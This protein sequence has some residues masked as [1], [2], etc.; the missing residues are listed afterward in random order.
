MTARELT[1]LRAPW[2]QVTGEARQKSGRGSVLG[3][4][5]AR[6]TRWWELPLECGH[7]E[8]RIVRYRPH[9]DGWPAQVGG[10]QHRGKDD[11]LPAPKRVRCDRCRLRL[12]P[13]PF[14]GPS[15]PAPGPGVPAG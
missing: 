11:V 15:R 3:P 1:E 13:G 7:T 9:Q 6:R 5:T 10:T 2:R 12:A 8:E 4:D 14:A